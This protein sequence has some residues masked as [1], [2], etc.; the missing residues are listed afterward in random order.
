[1]KRS[2][3]CAMGV[4]GT[5]LAYA[6]V[7]RPLS[8]ALCACAL[9]LAACGG[10]DDSSTPAKTTTTAQTEQEQGTCRDVEQP[11]PR[12]G[13]GQKKPKG[14]LAESKT[15]DVALQT[16]CGSFTIR[17]D[18]KTS[19]NAAASF[20]ALARSGFFDHTIFHRIVP[21]FVIQGGDPTVSGSG[22]P[23]Y[24]TRDKV[25]ANAKYGPGVVAMAK[26]GN[27]PAGTA[28]SQFFV[29]TGAGSGLT[30]DYAL[31]GKV[32]KGMEAVQAIGELGDPA[33][34]GTGTPLQSVVIEKATVR[35]H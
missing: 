29:V 7:F 30:P 6:A 31:L 21:G 22:G 19:P 23:G 15:Y 17:L 34:G 16:T 8:I 26:A 28:G 3:R 24:S 1:M 33:S 35:E 9:L 32:T 10:D 5:S 25:P 4:R 11:A 27:E 2:Y 18:Q 13:G 14:P 20:V 12:D